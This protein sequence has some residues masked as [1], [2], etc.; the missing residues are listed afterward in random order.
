MKTNFL[1]DRCGYTTIRRSNFINHLDRK[2]T[3]KPIKNN[4]LIEEIKEKYGFEKKNEKVSL[5]V[6]QKTRMKV[7]KCCVNF[8]AELM[9]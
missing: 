4:I 1:C 7:I 8:L 5:L 9:R 6:S 2:R 3:C